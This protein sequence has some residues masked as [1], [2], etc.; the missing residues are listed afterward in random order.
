MAVSPIITEHLTKRFRL[1]D[2]AVEEVSLTVP[3]GSIFGIVGTNGAGKTTL[4][5]MLLGL[6]RPTSGTARVLGVDPFAQDGSFRERIGFVTDQDYFFQY[7]T[8]AEVLRYGLLT[9]RHWDES[10]CTRLIE[11]FELP[12]KRQVRSLSKGMRIQ[13]AFITA[14]SIHPQLLL[15]DEPTSGLDAVVKR[16][17]LQL[18]VQE[19]A[20]GAT[21]LIAT[22][23]LDELERIADQVAFLHQGKVI[24]QSS[25]DEAKQNMRRIQ[26][27]FPDGLPDEVR[28]APGLLRIDESGHVYTLIVERNPQHVVELCRSFQ[29]VYLEEVEVAFEEL[30]I[31]V[32]HKEGYT[33]EQIILA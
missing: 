3:E 23:H 9:Y 27:V 28:R 19:A 24:L 6:I 14:L 4:I 17:I 12:R 33:R 20:G 15:L 5:H 31:H 7:F 8:V 29:P 11:A 21:I 25:T 16:Q 18:I 10:R 32:L 30:F 13:L 1:A 22:H 26:V 2:T